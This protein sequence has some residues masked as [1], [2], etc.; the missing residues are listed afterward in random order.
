MFVWNMRYPD[1]KS[2]EG[3]ILWAASLAGPRVV[4]GKYKV[5]LSMGGQS[6]E[7]EFEI[8][9]DPR[10]DSSPEELLAQFNFVREV[11][12]KINETH[13]TII[14]IRS[15]RQQ[16]NHFRSLWQNNAEMKP[17]LDKVNDIDKKITIIENELYQ[18]KNRSGQ[19]PLN[20]PIKLNNK[21][22][23]VGSSVNQ[24]NYGPTKQAV[25][26]KNELTKQINEQLQQFRQVLSSDLPELNRMVKE[27]GV[28]AIQ[29]KQEQKSS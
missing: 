20:Y 24:G 11:H 29:L 19:D 12:E 7:Q 2:F 23:A 13:Q 16:M 18:T 3:M 15:M 1:A 21:L 22:A 9:A 27:K 4:P 6:Q 25:E 14:D 26:V 10:A 17:L 8:L 28:D 5:R